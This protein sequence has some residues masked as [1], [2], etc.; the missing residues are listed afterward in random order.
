MAQTRQSFVETFQ[1][2]FRHHQAGQLQQAEALYRQVLATNPGHADSLHLLGVIARQVGQPKLAVEYIDQAISLQP[3]APAYHT[4]RGNALKDL[5][6]KAEAEASYREALRRQRDFPDALTNLGGLL[7]ELGRFEE[8]E[9]ICRKALR[10]RSDYSAQT[11]LGLALAG[12][13]RLEEAVA[14]H[15]EAVRLQPGS[16]DGHNNLGRALT[17]LDRTAEAEA[18]LRQAVRLR[19]EFADAL[20]NLG[21]VYRKVRGTASAASCFNL[22]VRA[23]PDFVEARINLADTLRILGCPADAEP[24]AREATRLSPN[25]ADAHHSLG[26]CLSGLEQHAEAE[27]CYRE[28]LRLRSDFPAALNNLGNA[29]KELE[30][31]PEAEAS[32]REVLRRHPHH[33]DAM[34]GLALVLLAQRKFDEAAVVVNDALSM[35]GVAEAAWRPLLGG[36][37]YMP[38]ATPEERFDKHLAFGRAMSERAAAQP[39]PPPSNDRTPGRRLRI[40]WLSSD[41]HRHP[42]ARNIGLFFRHRRREAFEFFCYADVKQPD[43]LTEAFK[44]QS[45]TWRSITGIDDADVAKLIRS[46]QIDIMIYLAGHFDGNRPQVAAWRPAP[47]QINM[48]DACTS[49]IAEMDYFLGDRI[50][51]PPR[52]RE[53]FSER[54][55]RLPTWYVHEAP[56]GGPAPVQP[57]CLAGGDVKFAS[58]HNPSKLHPKVFTL[59]GEILRRLPGAR[60]QFQ[61]MERFADK[62]LQQAVGHDLGDDVAPRVGFGMFARSIGDHLDLYNLIDI[63]LDPF[64]FTGS[65][66]TFEALWMG[67]PVVTLLG[68]T[69][70][71]RMTASAL[72]QVGLDDLIAESPEEYIDIAIRL[73]S[74][75][76]RLAELR[77]T[78]RDKLIKSPICNG[79]GAARHF[80]RALRAMWRKWCRDGDPP[81]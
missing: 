81:R 21:S 16:A 36:L 14:C 49:G 46:D 4:S 51:T 72:S 31:L 38:D 23:R 64:P 65:T 43:T 69:F 55:I 40:G 73:A 24:H 29:L 18:S 52:H 80:E 47:V 13:G 54:T 48:L 76:D 5:G 11:N 66:A 70:V 1:L 41:F 58:F 17:Q 34:K 60:L 77:R 12:L 59:W 71:S 75:R 19:P 10:A 20:N 22:A 37:L 79:P 3:R 9:P 78:L 42:V 45:D 68:D 61:Y 67:V 35:P 15:R 57:P 56:R 27:A 25:S 74:D 63:S 8:A 28:A 6:R 7:V 50:V 33:S 30:R 26:L 44:S 39:V 53:K 32:Y 2:G 62:K